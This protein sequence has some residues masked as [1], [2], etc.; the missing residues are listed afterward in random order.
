MSTALVPMYTRLHRT[1]PKCGD[2]RK[3]ERTSNLKAKAYFECDSTLLWASYCVSGAVWH[4]TG[5]YEHFYILFRLEHA[6]GKQKNRI[7]CE[8]IREIEIYGNFVGCFVISHA[9]WWNVNERI[10]ACFVSHRRALPREPVNQRESEPNKV[11]ALSSYAQRN[12]IQKIAACVKVPWGMNL[13]VNIHRKTYFNI[14]QNEN[15]NLSLSEIERTERNWTEFNSYGKESTEKVHTKIANIFFL[16][17]K[18]SPI[19]FASNRLS[20]KIRLQKP[21]CVLSHYH[22]IW[23]SWDVYNFYFCSR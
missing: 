11:K 7:L 13:N 12:T 17:K 8:R 21:T 6:R 9:G 14:Y 22:S 15:G 2:V 18:K 20:S 3:E 4:S 1:Q 10:F 19:F 23:P 16:R 5:M